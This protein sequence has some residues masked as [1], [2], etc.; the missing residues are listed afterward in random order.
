[1]LVDWKTIDLTEKP[2]PPN[3]DKIQ[4]KI[5][6][7]SK[8]INVLGVDL[9]YREVNP[10][11]NIKSSNKSVLLLHG[12]SFN[13]ETWLSLGTLTFLG[14]LGHRV[15]AID[16]PGYGKTKSK[17][18]GDHATFLKS[19]IDEL[20]LKQPVIVSPSMSGQYSVKFIA[21]H[22]NLISGYV[23]VAPVATSS[24]P[25]TLLRKIEVPT[26]IVY[27]SDDKTGLAETSLKHLLAMPN[28]REVKIENAGHPAYLN[29]PKLWHQLLFNFIL[30][31]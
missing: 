24:V 22:S 10:P 15:V 6:V 14:A 29:Q 7:N 20:H 9:F 25:E 26:L 21:D 11:D 13:S 8:T 31:L 1:M 17:Y 3:I 28:S 18:A 5:P 23:P 30:N 27:G 2:I 12:R 4:E 19:V 16:L